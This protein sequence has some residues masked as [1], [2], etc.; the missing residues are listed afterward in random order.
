MLRMRYIAI[1]SWLI[2]LMILPAPQSPLYKDASQPLERRVAD[3]VGRMTLDEKVAQTLAVWQQKR[4][5]VDASGAF[6]PGKAQAILQYGIG[7][8]TRV[9]DG[10]DRG[11]RRRSARET[12]E[13]ANAIQRWVVEHTRLGIP[14]MFHEEALHGLA[15][16]GSTHFPVPIGLASTWDP[17]LV[18]RVFTVA[19]REARARRTAGPLAGPRSCARSALG[20][21]RRDVR[22]GS[23]SHRG[24]RPRRDPR[25]SGAGP[26]PH[27]GACVRDGQTLRGARAARRRHQHRA[28]AGPGAPPA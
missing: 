21:H 1:S 23:A 16:V 19:A 10:V 22:R 28:D 14:V 15:A 8:I 12:V 27:A 26:F 9:S 24:D 2:G 17:A 6:D 5:L 3:L 4:G 11:G 25:L 18:E 20:P 13:L 7:Q